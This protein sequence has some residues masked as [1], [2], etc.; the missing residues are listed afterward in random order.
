MLSPMIVAV[1]YVVGLWAGLAIGFVT[2]YYT[3]HSYRPVREVRRRARKASL[4]PRYFRG[5]HRQS[6]F[7]NGIGFASVSSGAVARQKVRS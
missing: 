4:H 5:C 7:Q 1:C 6:F 2:E 3:S